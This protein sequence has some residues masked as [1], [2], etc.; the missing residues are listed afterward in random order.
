MKERG[1]KFSHNT[2]DPANNTS[3]ENSLQLW[4]KETHNRYPWGSHTTP[5]HHSY[6]MNHQMGPWHSS[7]LGVTLTSNFIKPEMVKW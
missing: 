4:N 3:R 7:D 6:K 1:T 2:I 5:P